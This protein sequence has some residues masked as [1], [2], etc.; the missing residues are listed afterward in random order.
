MCRKSYLVMSGVIFAIIAIGHL[1][2]LV[3]SR[4]LH[5]SFRFLAHATSIT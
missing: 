2:R 1:G 3:Y 5:S 4:K